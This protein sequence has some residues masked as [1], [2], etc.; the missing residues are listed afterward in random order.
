MERSGRV[1]D[2]YLEVVPQA[3]P[4]VDYFHHVLWGLRQRI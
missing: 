4:V 1:V 2:N 3:H